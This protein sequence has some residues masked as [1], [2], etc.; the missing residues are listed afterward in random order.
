MDG[1]RAF[2]DGKTLLSRY[3]N[4]IHC[5]SWF[6]E[7]LPSVSL[8]GELWMGR[9]TFEKLLSVLKSNHS[10]WWDIRYYIFDLPS[11]TGTFEERMNEMERL[12]PFL[13]SH[14]QIVE[15]RKCTTKKQ[16][17][18]YLDLIVSQKGE[19]IM[20]RAPQTLYIVGLNSSLLKVKV[21]FSLSFITLSSATKT[22]K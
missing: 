6:T 19:G 22:Q 9:D 11:S 5:P 1:V 3:G 12:K 8:D 20:A 10:N 21:H 2:W 17:E 16:L 7:G 14:V 18:D 4:G 15:N 13:P